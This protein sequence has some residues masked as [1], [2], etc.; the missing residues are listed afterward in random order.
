MI[1]W[2]DSPGCRPVWSQAVSQR[3]PGT[4]MR[5]PAVTPT[6]STT[7]SIPSDG[8]RMRY[9][10]TGPVAGWKVVARVP[11]SGFTDEIGLP[12][13]VQTGGRALRWLA[14]GAAEMGAPA[15]A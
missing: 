15:W 11:S 6:D 3:F 8:I 13:R 9:G 2:P 10:V 5:P 4:S 12:D 7:V 14:I 1:A